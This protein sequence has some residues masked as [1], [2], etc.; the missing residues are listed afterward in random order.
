M[1]WHYTD[2]DLFFWHSKDGYFIFCHFWPFCSSSS[3]PSSFSSNSSSWVTAMA[4]GK[5]DRTWSKL[6]S[7]LGCY[8]LLGARIRLKC[9]F[10]QLDAHRAWLA[11]HGQAKRCG[12]C[13]CRRLLLPFGSQSPSSPAGSRWPMLMRPTPPPPPTACSKKCSARP[14][15]RNPMMEG[16]ITGQ[17]RAPLGTCRTKLELELGARSVFSVNTVQSINTI[18]YV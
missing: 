17:G 2:C 5:K 11:R 13:G 15:R 8:P 18:L 12:E 16:V 6:S 1:I 9:L 4:D 7:S 14:C 10:A 3:S